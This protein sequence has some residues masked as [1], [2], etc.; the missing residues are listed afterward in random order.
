MSK[1]NYVGYCKLKLLKA[2]L[3]PCLAIGLVNPWQ[4]LLIVILIGND[5]ITGIT[6]A[7]CGPIEGVHCTVFITVNRKFSTSAIHGL[8]Y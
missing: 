5:L 3:K 1:Q 7:W 8:L 6:A 2:P 4:G